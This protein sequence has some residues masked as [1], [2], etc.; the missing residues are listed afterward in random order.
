MAV[1]CRVCRQSSPDTWHL[2]R[3]LETGT[4]WGAGVQETG[5]QQ[6][7]A[8]GLKWGDVGGRGR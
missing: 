6:Q 3:D 2:G 7:G 5:P 1:L 8:P 4:L